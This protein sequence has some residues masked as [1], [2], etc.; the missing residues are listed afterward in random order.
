[1]DFLVLLIATGLVAGAT[2]GL[3]AIGFA[4]IYKATGVVNFAQGELV[5]LTAYI[6]YSLAGAFGLTF[7]PLLLVAVPISMAVGLVLERIFIRP[8]LGE[9]PF[10]IVMVTVGLAVILRGL[11]IVVWGSQPANFD[12]GIPTTVIRLGNVPFY[13]AQ[14]IMIA[15]LGLVVLAMWAFM[16][17]SRYGIA[18][19]AVAANETAALLT[20]VSVSRIHALAWVLSSGIAA[21]AGMLFAA[22]FKLAPDLWFQGLKSFPAVI[23]GGM[24]SIVGAAVGGIAIGLIESLS[25]GYI[26]EGMREIAG[27]IVIILVLMVRPYGLF[28]SRDI[29]RV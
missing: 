26:G 19:R 12:A 21:I 13:P 23:L 20:G 10:A 16:R 27:F 11:I 28:G 9:P 6:G 15:A 5:M 29:E 17:F 1:M 22:N 3:I 4:L 2:Y 14:L 18:M 25:Q 7:I 8:M 24:D